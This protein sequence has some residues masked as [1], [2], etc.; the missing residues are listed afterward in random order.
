M[1][2]CYRRQ[3]QERTSENPTHNSPSSV[4]A[5][6]SPLTTQTVIRVLVVLGATGG[7]LLGAFMAVVKLLPERAS[8]ITAYQL[9]TI[10]GLQKE[11]DR[12]RKEVVELRERVETLE[13]HH[14]NPS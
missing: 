7:S 11:N 10:E 1:L 2:S 13:A 8:V 4:P 5:E 3:R 6:F 14:S 9:K 12:M